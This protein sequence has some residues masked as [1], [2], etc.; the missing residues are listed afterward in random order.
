M[1]KA[2]KYRS[3]SVNK[4]EID[5]MIYSGFLRQT[6]QGQGFN[7]GLLF[8]SSILPIGDNSLSGT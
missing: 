4:R 1:E 3:V 2:G 5:F 7:L 8:S 6:W